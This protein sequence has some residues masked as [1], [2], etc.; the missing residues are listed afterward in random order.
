MNKTLEEQLKAE[1]QKGFIDG[2]N[3]TGSIAEEDYAC[4]LKAEKEKLIKEIYKGIEGICNIP[5]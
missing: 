4:R 3:I 2:S 1:Y 5:K